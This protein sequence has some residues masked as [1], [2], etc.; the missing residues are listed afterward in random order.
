MSPVNLSARYKFVNGNSSSS[1]LNSNLVT[2]GQQAYGTTNS[3]RWGEKSPLLNSTVISE[4]LASKSFVGNLQAGVSWKMAA[5]LL[6]N[7]ALGAGMLNYPYA[8][9]QTGGVI[10]A[11]LMQAVCR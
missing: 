8:Y 7:T 6:V 2:N 1:H 3:P 11:A 10:C 9:G 5:F 4:S